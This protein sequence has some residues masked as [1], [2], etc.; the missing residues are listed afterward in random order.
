MLIQQRHD[1]S[2]DMEVFHGRNRGKLYWLIRATARQVDEDH[3][4]FKSGVGVN[5]SRR[6]LD[7]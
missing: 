4:L 5:V 1:A 7:R 6:V 2:T 3:N